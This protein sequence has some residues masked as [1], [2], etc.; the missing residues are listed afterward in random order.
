MDRDT[1]QKVDAVS[2]VHAANGAGLEGGTGYG[3]S[4]SGSVSEA[5]GMSRNCPLCNITPAEVLE[6]YPRWR[7]VRTKTMKGH[8]ERLMLLHK[9]HV[10]SLDEKSVEEAYRLLLKVGRRYFS[11]AK[12]WAIFEPVFATVPDHWHRV[13]SDL[14]ASASDYD[15]ILKT[16]RTIVDNTDGGTRRLEPIGRSLGPSTPN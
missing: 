6:E 5:D 1:E 10:R 11:Y 9:G 8:K 2:L 13:A 14:D 7:L 16:P 4:G 3:P 15:Q 12:E